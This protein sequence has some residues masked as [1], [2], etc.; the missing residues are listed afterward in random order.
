[1]AKHFFDKRDLQSKT[2]HPRPTRGGGHGKGCL[3]HGTRA[4]GGAGLP[5]RAD[6][7]A[8]DGGPCPWSVW[9]ALPG[10]GG[11]DSIP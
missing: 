6:P 11:W 4:G 2:N 1:M 9:L 7:S 3:D 5:G 10:G 8:W